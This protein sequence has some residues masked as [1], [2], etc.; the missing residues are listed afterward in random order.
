MKVKKWVG[1]V[2]LLMTSVLLICDI[3]LNQIFGPELPS[4]VFAAL[5]GVAFIGTGTFIALEGK[6]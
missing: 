1:T 4:L 2:M 3:G 5:I 6:E